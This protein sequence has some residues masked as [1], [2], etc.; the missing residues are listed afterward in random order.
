MQCHS[1]PGSV[2]FVA[3]LPVWS[4][5]RVVRGVQCPS[6]AQLPQSGLTLTTRWTVTHQAPL[7]M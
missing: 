6:G 3:P 4:S 1:G 2:F 5:A 7:S